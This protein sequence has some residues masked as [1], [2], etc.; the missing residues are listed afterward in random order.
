MINDLAGMVEEFVTGTAAALDWRSLLLVLAVAYAALAAAALLLS[1]RMMF[2]PPTASYRADADLIE[3][4]TSD[5]VRIAALHLPAGD[6]RFTILFSHGNAEDLG[7]LRPVLEELRRAGFS[8]LA[9]DYRGYGLSEARRPTERGVVRDLTAAYEH[10]T[11]PL[12]MPPERVILHGRSVGSGPTLALA[13]EHPVGGVIL[14]SAFTTAFRV[15]TRAPIFPFDRFHNLSR[16]RRLDAP[17]LVIHGTRDEII[18][19]AHGRTL[20]DAA[21]GPKQALWVEGAGHNDLL[22]VAG[23]DYRRALRAFAALLE[24]RGTAAP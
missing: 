14:E 7:H 5:G 19:F 9:Y 16:I 13:A 10:L 15:V 11:G 1:E 4:T 12:G 6:A 22:S 3:L 2:F 24:E 20:H 17:V 18:P 8:V 21:P 23:A